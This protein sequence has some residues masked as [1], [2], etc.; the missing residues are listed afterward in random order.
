[1]KQQRIFI[2]LAAALLSGSLV[3]QNL[4]AYTLNLHPD[5]T[6]Y[7][8]LAG[9]KAYSS[10]DAAGVKETLDLGLFLTLSGKQEVLEWYN[11]KKD[12]EK[13]P[14]SLTGN[15]TA[16]VAISFDRDQ[17][18]KCKTTADLRRMTG[19]LTKN[20]FSHFAVIKNSESSYQRCFI[21]ERSDGKRALLYVTIGAGN[22]VKTEIKSE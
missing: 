15:A 4:S 8:S 13:V 19:Y 22:E 1:M 9:K 11:L 17:F 5:K 14:A 21:T 3:A 16:V 7:L 20:S 2:F 18:D 6:P 10:A 12:N